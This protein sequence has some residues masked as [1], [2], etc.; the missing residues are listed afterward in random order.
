MLREHQ[1]WMQWRRS[2]SLQSMQWYTFTWR[3]GGEGGGGGAGG[4]CVAAQGCGDAAW[5][6]VADAAEALLFLAGY[7][8][9]CCALPNRATALAERC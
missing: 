6:S 8:M 9:A 2:C 1:G 3:G 4:R 7:T 5:A